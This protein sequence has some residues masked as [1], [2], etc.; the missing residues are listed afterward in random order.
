VAE[1]STGHIARIDPAR[2]AVVDRTYVGDTPVAAW[3]SGGH[4]YFVSVE[5]SRR[6]W[7]FEEG[8]GV[9]STDSHQIDPKGVPGQVIIRPGTQEVWIAVEDRGVVAIFDSVSH[10]TIAEFSAGA[11][12]HGIV[13][14][15]DGS[16]AFVTDEGAGRVL[17]IDGATRT[18]SREL[19]VG[20]KPNGIAWFA[21]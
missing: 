21:R 13:F 17:V 14:T 16:R 11:K 9:V 12:P 8:A 2:R 18:I 7:H 15:P 1:S 3:A 19:P 10:A 4:S 6:V 5:G 20:D